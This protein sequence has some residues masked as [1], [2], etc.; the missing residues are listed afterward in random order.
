MFGMGMPEIL[1]I[2]AIALIVIG[3]KKLPEL[4]KSLGRAM[5]EF[6]KATSDLKE[7]I[8]SEYDI[9]EVKKTFDDVKNEIKAPLDITQKPSDTKPPELPAADAMPN[10]TETTETAP[11]HEAEINDT[12][13]W[14]AATDLPF[15]LMTGDATTETDTEK[16]TDADEGIEK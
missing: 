12:E 13:D 1:L 14:E 8:S 3:P 4:A 11:E 2:L 9:D 5:N 16:K 10:A 15:E 6:K 7:S